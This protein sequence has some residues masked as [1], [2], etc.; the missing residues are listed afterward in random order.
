[1]I[2][3]DLRTIYSMIDERIRTDN[4]VVI[5]S[6]AMT[7][8]QRNDARW[9]IKYGKKRIILSTPAAFFHDRYRLTD[10]QVVDSHLRYYKNRQN[11]RYNVSAVVAQRKAHLSTTSH[12][13]QTEQ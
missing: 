5:L 8:K 9:A 6:S 11:P 10:I 4:A 7:E 12:S 13:M 2:F 3:P 1:M